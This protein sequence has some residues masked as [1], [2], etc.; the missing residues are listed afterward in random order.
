MFVE[1]H[2]YLSSLIQFVFPAQKPVWIEETPVGVSVKSTFLTSNGVIER[3]KMH[4]KHGSLDL[5]SEEAM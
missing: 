5:K 2:L 1:S 4:I 3:K